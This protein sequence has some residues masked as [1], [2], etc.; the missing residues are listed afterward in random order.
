MATTA[1]PQSLKFEWRTKINPDGG[2]VRGVVVDH[3]NGRVWGA[4]RGGRITALNLDGGSELWVTAV[5]H[6]LE[7]K[8]DTPLVYNTVTDELA[9]VAVGGGGSVLDAETGDVVGSI[10]NEARGIAHNSNDGTWYGSVS[11]GPAGEVRFKAYASGSFEVQWVSRVFDGGGGFIQPVA[12]SEAAGIVAGMTNE[13]VV[14][15]NL[16]DGTK[17][18]RNNSPFDRDIFG[19]VGT[20]DAILSGARSDP[21]F[22]GVFSGDT[23]GLLGDTAFDNAGLTSLAAFPDTAAQVYALF[24]SGAVRAFDKNMQSLWGENVGSRG[25]SLDV[26]VGAEDTVRLLSGDDDGRLTMWVTDHTAPPDAGNGG[27]GGDIIK[28]FGG[29]GTLAVLL[30]GVASGSGGTVLEQSQF[31]SR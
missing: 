10:P 13:D 1:G 2:N 20:G 21:S 19:V 25:T 26:A 11:A 6:D 16:K 17:R 28:A 31:P 24:P 5:P 27:D 15:L 14:A 22:V 4:D 23:G 8:G 18:W 30:A 12:T 9:A 7:D 29:R 3:A